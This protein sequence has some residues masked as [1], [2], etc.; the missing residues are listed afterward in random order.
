MLLIGKYKIRLPV[1]IRRLQTA[2]VARD[3][4]DVKVYFGLT[5]IH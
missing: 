1:K 3:K 5:E 4:S 2:R